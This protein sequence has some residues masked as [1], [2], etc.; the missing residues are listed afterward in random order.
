MSAAVIA[1][2]QKLIG[3]PR[4][5]ALLRFSLGSEYLK[6]GDAR[7]ARLQLAEAVDRDPA[8]SAAWKLYGKALAEDGLL[9]AALDAYRRGIAV[10]ER[11]GD[12]Q[13]A[14]EM[15]VLAK[16]IQK[17]LESGQPS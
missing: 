7:N 9:Q 16:R 3:T 2:L 5:G 14:Q 8:Y 12:K 4:D 13:A 17:Q 10:A 15:A 1:N 6:A 11:K